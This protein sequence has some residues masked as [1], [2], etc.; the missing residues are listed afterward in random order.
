MSLDAGGGHAQ[1]LDADAQ[2][3][4]RG[5]HPAFVDRLPRQALLVVVEAHRSGA[6]GE[7]GAVDLVFVAV[8]DLDAVDDEL[9]PVEDRG[10]ARR[11]PGARLV[12]AERV[13]GQEHRG[14]PCCWVS[15]SLFDELPED[16][17]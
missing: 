8:D 5:R 15:N 12:T 10:G 2:A 16:R 13:V 6:L 7:R 3:D 11:E 4:A 14:R 17:P 9:E 1:P